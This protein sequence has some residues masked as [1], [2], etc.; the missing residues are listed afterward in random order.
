[1]GPAPRLAFVV[2]VL[3]ALPSL[4]GAQGLGD[5]SAKEKQRRQESKTPKAKTYTQDELLALP[6][7]ANEDPTPPGDVGALPP[8]GAVALPPRDAV[9]LP[10]DRGLG[11]GTT[12]AAADDEAATR[13]RDE[14]RWRSR[15]AGARASVEKARKRYQTFAGLTL[16]PGYEYVD[17]RGRTLIQ[18]VEELQHLTAAAKAELDAA[19]KALDDLLEEARRANVPPGWLR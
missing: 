10:P 2:V 19:Q 13:A 11:T 18:S 4:A 14:E 16:V 8:V 12:S 5:A 17:D 9:A 3:F 7:V 15:V 1:M 6:P